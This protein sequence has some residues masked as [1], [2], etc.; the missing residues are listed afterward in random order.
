MHAYAYQNNY[1]C[2]MKASSG[3]AFQRI[4]EEII[5][6][7]KHYSIYGAAWTESL[8]VEHIRIDDVKKIEVIQGSK[9]IKSHFSNSLRLIKEDLNAGITV[10]FSGTP[11]Q[12]AAV[13]KYAEKEKIST[14]LLYTIEIICHGTSETKVWKDSL[15]WT[16]HKFSS[17]IRKVDFRDKQIGWKHYPTSYYFENGSS[18]HAT[19]EA[20]LYIRLFMS[21]LV[22]TKGCFTCPYANTVRNADITIGDF[23]GIEDVMPD[24]PIGNGVS[25]VLAND[26]KGYEVVKSIENSLQEDELIRRCVDDSF[27]KYQHNLNSATQKPTNYDE[28][29][30]DYN[31]RGFD[32]V[33]RKYKFYTLYWKLRFYARKVVDRLKRLRKNV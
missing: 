33:I 25:L 20:Q 31:Y 10:V 8:E 30:M 4:T 28:F 29:W 13:L 1:R 3:G 26:L 12:V 2:V 14:E 19:Y 18:I 6:S 16:E 32:F 5:S 23:W 15:K 27:M 7:T 17:R 9:Y 11:C 24:F 21:S 22:T